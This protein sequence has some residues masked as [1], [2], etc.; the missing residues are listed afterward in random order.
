VIKVSRFGDSAWTKTARIEV[1]LPD[2]QLKSYFLKV[3]FLLYED[4]RVQS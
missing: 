1:I 3:N 4:S 2:G